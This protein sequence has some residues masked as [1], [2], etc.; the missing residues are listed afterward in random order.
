MRLMQIMP[1]TY[2]ELQL[3]H[4]LGADP[5]APR[6]NILDGAAYLRGTRDLYG[7]GG[8]LAAYN[9]GAGRHDDYPTHGG[10]F[11]KR[12][13]NGVQNGDFRCPA[14]EPG[15]AKAPGKSRFTT[16]ISQFDDRQSGRSMTLFAIVQ[17]VFGSTAAAAK[18]I[19][20]TAL[21]RRQIMHS[22]RL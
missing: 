17:S 16:G 6:N 4:H 5:Y 8:F 2:A 10:R 15:Q 11:R 13:F 14:R 18:T 22:K 21:N 20:M 3:R 7:R 12:R 9:A 19:D 1:E